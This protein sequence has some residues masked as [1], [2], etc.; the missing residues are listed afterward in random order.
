LLRTEDV[1]SVQ[2][3]L[4]TPEPSLAETFTFTPSVPLVAMLYHP[5]PATVSPASVVIVITGA[6][7]S[8]M[9]VTEAVAWAEDRPAAS[10]ETALIVLGPQASGTARRVKFGAVKVAAE[11]LTVTLATPLVASFAVPL[12]LIVEFVVDGGSASSETIGIVVSR[13]IVWVFDD[14]PPALVAVQVIPVVPSVL[15]VVV[16]ASVGHDAERDVT[17]DSESDTVKLTVTLP[18]LYQPFEPFGLVGV[19]TGVIVGGVVSAAE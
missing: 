18:A 17:V 12:T 2:L 16:N 15:T 5:L 7:V 8:Q 19:T 3:R 11:P 10:V 14:V 4:A 1:P 6:A 13:L 9:R